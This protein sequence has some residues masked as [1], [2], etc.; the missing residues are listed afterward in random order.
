MKPDA[1]ASAAGIPRIGEVF[2][3]RY[4][5]ERSLG[6]GSMGAVFVAEHVS[7]RQ[8]VAVKFLLPRAKDFP[9]ASARFLREARAA[10]AIRSEHV[11][12][13]IDVG[14][15]ELGLPYIVMEHLRGR[16]LQQVLDARGPLPVS[17]AVD[18][19]LQ[20]CEAVA[21]AHARGIV[22]RDLK[23]GN[24]FLTSGPSGVP[25]VKVLDFGLSKSAED[26]AEEDG[27]LT[28]SEMMLGSPCYMSPEQVRC[29]KDVDARTDVWALG[30]I[31]Y[32]LLTARFPF[33]A[34][35]VS[36]LF[37]AIVTDA[38][39][40]PRVHRWELPVHLEEVILRCLEKDVQQRLQSVVELSRALAPYGTEHSAR[41]LDQIEAIAA[42]K[43]FPSLPP[44]PPDPAASTTPAGAARFQGAT[45][46]WPR[47]GADDEPDG[48]FSR[49]A[50][51][52]APGG[53]DPVT[54]LP[55]PGTAADALR[56]RDAAPA[57]RTSVPVSS[58][59]GPTLMMAREDGPTLTMARED[60]PTLTMAREDGPT[61][62]MAHDDGPT[63]PW[64]YR[65]LAARPLA[66]GEESIG[67][68][69]VVTERRPGQ[70]SSLMLRKRRRAAARIAAAASLTAAVAVGVTLWSRRP[71]S[72]SNVGLPSGPA[73]QAPAHASSLD[74]AGEPEAPAS[75]GEALEGAAGTAAP[76]QPP[77]PP[78][79]AGRG[80]A[81][82]PRP[83]PPGP[84]RPSTPG[85]TGRCAS[86]RTLRRARRAAPRATPGRRP[87]TTPRPRSATTGS[88]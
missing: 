14:T 28:A 59:E 71:E 56:T 34:P 73:S 67:S 9:G 2:A 68:V 36:A 24:L 75:V 17:E 13:V 51:V 44:P 55:S 49:R 60:G 38:P 37:V 18:Y 82:L 69:P 78:R 23:P 83:P 39:R 48:R 45:V 43:A 6:R 27:K 19:V 86:R 50:T 64:P 42:G 84:R 87:F 35:S 76:A 29:T 20:S 10:A 88:W 79:P 31:L 15:A 70:Q 77:A 52:V 63:L 66:N 5:L 81:R 26:A 40:P 85:W 8:R 61:L 25:V 12:R 74:A 72:S 54:T 4:R 30:I 16:D 62:T 21:E 11:A 3:Q 41:A 7:L 22:H 47:P 57:E 32:Q 65:L 46:T 1:P 80:R 53:G 58:D 33:D